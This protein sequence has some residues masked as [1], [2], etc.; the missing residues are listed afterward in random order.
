M[1]L[2][3]LH[4]WHLKNLYQIL[5]VKHCPYLHPL[6]GE[7]YPWKMQKCFCSAGRG[8]AQ[9]HSCSQESKDRS[10]SPSF[11]SISINGS[12]KLLL[13]VTKMSETSEQGLY[14][15]KNPKWSSVAVLRYCCIGYILLPDKRAGRKKWG[16]CA[17]PCFFFISSKWPVTDVC[18]SCI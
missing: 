17:C 11:F 7:F 14:H 3:S 1:D 2:L 8:T 4:I 6:N 13:T 5:Y 16:F 15:V 18:S 10:E 12:A 9:P